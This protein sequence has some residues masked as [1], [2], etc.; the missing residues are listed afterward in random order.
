[1]K[2]LL[3]VLLGLAL[4]AAAWAGEAAKPAFEVKAAYKA[5]CAMCHGGDAKGN[6]A[7]LK[8]LKAKPAQLDLAAGDASKLS[9]AEI[10]KLV[11]DGK[12]RMPAFKGKLE[13]E[14]VK[15]LAKYL[16]SLRKAAAKTEKAAEKAR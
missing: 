6:A 1:M 3:P 2:A 11:T 14:A 12:G 16:V 7:M 4:G 8:T 5:K 13:P 15:S 9:E 10:A